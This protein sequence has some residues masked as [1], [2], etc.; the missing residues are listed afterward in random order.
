ME[1][2]CQGLIEQSSSRRAIPRE[3]DKTSHPHEKD[4]YT[5]RFREGLVRMGMTGDELT[6][7]GM[8]FDLFRYR[9]AHLPEGCINDLHA[10]LKAIEEKYPDLRD[11]DFITYPLAP[12]ILIIMFATAAGFTDP[13]SIR[14]YI[15][16][17]MTAICALLQDE[18]PGPEYV[19]SVSTIHRARKIMGSGFCHEYFREY[20]AGGCG[21]RPQAEYQH[22]SIDFSLSGF[23]YRNG[24]TEQRKVYACDGQEMSATYRPGNYDRRKKGAQLVTLYNTTDRTVADFEI[25]NTKN[26]ERPAMIEML[27]RLRINGAI[28][29]ADALNTT[30][31]VTSCICNTAGSYLMPV[32]TNGGNK[33]LRAM[34]ETAFNKLDLKPEYSE[35]FEA[36]LNHGR[37]ETVTL[38][39]LDASCLQD[40]WEHMEKERLKK[41]GIR[42]EK[43]RPMP[44]IKHPQLLTIIKKTKKTVQIRV[45]EPS[46]ADAA[47]MKKKSGG[48][49]PR[50]TFTEA[51]Y[52][53][54]LP[55]TKETF[56][57]ILNAIHQYWLCEGH[58]ATLDCSNLRQDE[59]V[60][61]DPQ[62][63]RARAT[64]NKCVVE[65][66][67]FVRQKLT[68][69]KQEKIKQSPKHRKGAAVVPVSWNAAMMAMFNPINALKYWHG[70][71]NM[72]RQ[73][74]LNAVPPEPLTRYQK[75]LL[76]QMLRADF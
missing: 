30:A 47:A 32:K 18:W 1:F 75:T 21:E 55:Y 65:F 56:V 27:S 51:Y 76:E 46:A 48:G 43:I 70:F 6:E 35:S 58:H 59:I 22:G 19:P 4:D 29:M 24:D 7:A 74:N 42:G 66:L 14:R 31:D 69:Q 20:F 28:V 68:E 15:E 72:R 36:P 49:V 11:P 61:R 73:N 54:S 5:A 12:L 64:I 37:I 33:V 63:L 67:S 39:M 41:E 62:V 40:A 60:G 8:S 3:E 71:M 44:K 9:A 23:D 57:S 45:N 13:E 38:S 10:G 53:C 34:P 50:P 52:I 2:K 16:Y 17:N 26:Q 25:K